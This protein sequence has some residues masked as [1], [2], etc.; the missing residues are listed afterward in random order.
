M[1]ASQDA[2]FR[3][4]SASFLIPSAY[5]CCFILGLTFSFLSI[6][7]LKL[8]FVVLGFN[9]VVLFYRIVPIRYFFIYNKL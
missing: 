2:S 7:L 8:R 1:I 5:A 4:C 3:A 6:L 9:T